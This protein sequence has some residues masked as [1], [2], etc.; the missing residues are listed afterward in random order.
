MAEWYEWNAKMLLEVDESYTDN[1]IG[2]HLADNI[3][4]PRTNGTADILSRQ[5][6]RRETFAKGGHGD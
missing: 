6:R 5:E 2:D 1:F 3:A 4:T